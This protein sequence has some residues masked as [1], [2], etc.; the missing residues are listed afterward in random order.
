MRGPVAGIKPTSSISSTEQGSIKWIH[1][2]N[3]ESITTHTSDAMNGLGSHRIIDASVRPLTKSPPSVQNEA[4]R[5]SVSA[6]SLGSAHNIG[7]DR[8]PS[9][10][11][12]PSRDSSPGASLIMKKQH[13]RPASPA[14]EPP[15]SQAQAGAPHRHEISLESA[16]G[17]I[18]FYCSKYGFPRA[19]IIYNSKSKATTIIEAIMFIGGN[20]VGTGSGCNMK[21]ATSLCY[22][23]ACLWMSSCDDSLW[24]Q[25][26]MLEAT[27]KAKE[28][29]ATQRKNQQKADYVPSVELSFSEKLD[30]QLRS[31]I[32][33]AR[34]SEL[35]RQALRSRARAEAGVQRFKE[36]RDKAAANLASKGAVNQNKTLNI[37]DTNSYTYVD[38]MKTDAL[39]N[40]SR[41]LQDRQ[42]RYRSD[43]RQAKMRETRASLPISNHAR[44]LMKAIEENPVV[45]VMAQTG[46]GKTTQLPQIILDH[47]I[48][49]GKGATCN[50]ICTQPRR[51]AAISVA[52]RVATERG[53]PPG[54]SV[55]YQ[56]RFENTFPERDGSILFMTSGIFLKRMQVGLEDLTSGKS[57]F[58][59][60]VS[61]I[62]VDEV[63]ERDIDVDLLLFT[64]RR[65][66]IERRMV[67]KPDFKVILMCVLPREFFRA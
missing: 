52:Q 63:H 18:D 20:R 40:K 60:E 28:T 14:K 39:A 21:E 59:D 36:Q 58:L 24:Y 3:K 46:S 42:D 62:I 17:F 10:I 33:E 12:G 23:D 19:D 7:S 49:N 67:G 55:G 4:T 43:P 11:A 16:R 8:S 35:H 31:V 45:V 65:Q 6:V 41:E 56:V 29:R 53:E 2:V 1:P 64:L 54:K 27:N 9:P 66:L 61:H 44:D 5:P 30:A 22:I 48:Q 51:L 34:K 26:L 13:S 25:F 32:W 50:V 38:A 37:G 15:Q 57:S 47:Y